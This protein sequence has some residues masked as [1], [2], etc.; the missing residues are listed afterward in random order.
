M[1]STRSGL[2]CAI[3]R[4]AVC[5]HDRRAASSAVLN[6]CTNSASILHVLHRSVRQNSMSEVE[7]VSRP[8]IR[9]PQDVLRA[10]LHFLHDANSVTGSRLPCTACSWP[11]MR[12]PSSSGIRQSSPMHLRARL[13]HRGQQRGAVGA[14]IDDGHTWFLFAAAAPAVVVG[15]E[16]I[17]PIVLDAQA[18]HPAIEDLDHV[19][20]VPHLL[21][22]HT[23]P[24]RPPAC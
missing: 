3:S 17:A 10:L 24:A 9:Q 6:S 15:I 8:P 5:A 12:Q 18:A 22:R 23:P 14:E 21:R 4:T 11:T 13:R 7:D 19:G 20:A 1:S 2:P 16:R